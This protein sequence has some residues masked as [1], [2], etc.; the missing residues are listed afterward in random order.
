LLSDNI[1]AEILKDKVSNDPQRLAKE[2]LLK[3]N[4]SYLNHASIG[5]VPKVIHEA[6][7]KYLEICESNPSLYVWGSIWKEVTENTRQLASSLIHCNVDDLAITHNTT[8]G[9]NILAHGLQLSQNDEVL[10]S[11]LNHAGASMPWKGLSE[12]KNFQVRTFDFPINKISE[13]DEEDIINLHISQIRSNTK[14]LIFPHIDNIIGLRHPMKKIATKAKQKGVEFIFVDGA[15]SVGMI[16][17]RLSNSNVDAYSMS[18]HKWLQAPK[19]TGM[20]YVNKKLR[21]ELPRMWYKT[22]AE[23]HDGSARKYEDY[24]T[25]AW[26]AVVALGDAIRFQNTLGQKKKNDYYKSLWMKTKKLV[27]KDKNLLW[28]SPNEWD[29]SSAIMSIEVLN[30]DA[31]ELT[32]VLDKNFNIYLRPFGKPLNAIRVSPNMFNGF[33]EIVNLL[34]IVTKKI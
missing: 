29:L 18:P 5:T 17:V 7:V 13:I 14:V 6:H 34:K 3:E 11:S 28:H 2:Y 32:R 12:I 1:I 26:P 25:R 15:Q 10:F 30:K 4:S 31:V 19:G 20:F 23:R 27:N 24:S 16:P 22:P 33:Q 8:E 9:F 21:K